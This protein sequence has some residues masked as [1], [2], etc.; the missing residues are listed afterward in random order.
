MGLATGEGSSEQGKKLNSC[1]SKPADCSHLATSEPRPSKTP[2][3][4]MLSITDALHNRSSVKHAVVQ[5]KALG[6]QDSS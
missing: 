5:G 2:L 3:K 6:E 4:L 1:A